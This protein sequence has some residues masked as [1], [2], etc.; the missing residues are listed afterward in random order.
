MRLFYSFLFWLAWPWL[1][2]DN[3]RRLRAQPVETRRQG[4]RFGVLADDMPQGGIWLHAVSLGET[5]AAFALLEQLAQHWPGLPLVV[6]TTTETGAQAARGFTGAPIRHFYAPYD[7]PSAVA[8]LLDTLRPHVL[9]VMET[10]LWPNLF[11]GARARGVAVVVVNARL[12]DRSYRGYRR[13]A[14]SLAR[15]VLED[16]AL[17]LAQDT[18]DA[19]RFVALG[20]DPARVRV[21]GNLKFDMTPPAEAVEQGRALRA[22]WPWPKVWVAASTHEGE[23]ERVLDAQRALR[24]AGLAVLLVLVPRHPQRF[25]AVARLLESRGLPYARRSRGEAVSPDTSVCLADTVGELMCF[26]ASADVAFV[27]GSLVPVGGHNL[28]EPA[29]LGLPV[30]SGPHLHNFREIATRLREAQALIVVEEADALTAALHAL[31]QDADRRTRC[32]AAALAVVEA[33][34]GATARVVAA[35]ASLPGM[36][37]NEKGQ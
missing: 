11:A 20:A 32:G 4:E 10:E 7:L 37:I 29:A 14:G 3:R 22:H 17:I 25:E 24:E 31:L 23:E 13:W 33:N 9:L 30:V 6:S 28:L 18:L 15:A 34:R 8:R 12:S 1:W 5:R 21:T 27:G 19:Q 26:Y 2:L 36:G 16:A 35:L